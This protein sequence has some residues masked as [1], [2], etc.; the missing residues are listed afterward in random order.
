MSVAADFATDPH[1][2][3]LSKAVT[4]NFAAA[5]MVVAVGRRQALY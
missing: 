1:S 2:D 5:T 4:T 3:H